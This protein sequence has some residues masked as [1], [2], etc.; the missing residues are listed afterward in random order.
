M[1][2]AFRALFLIHWV[3]LNSSARVK[4]RC[5]SQVQFRRL[6]DGNM[7]CTYVERKVLLGAI[8]W[9]ASRRSHRISKGLGI[10]PYSPHSR[11]TSFKT[12][13]L[14]VYPQLGV[15]IYLLSLCYIWHLTMCSV[16][17]ISQ[18]MTKNQKTKPTTIKN[19]NTRQP[20]R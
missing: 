5:G 15:F 17:V 11:V 20:K 4:L 16:S 7:R 12:K 10:C 8:A 18:K 13:S 9:N 2:L 6:C 19:G 3:R 14:P 1:H